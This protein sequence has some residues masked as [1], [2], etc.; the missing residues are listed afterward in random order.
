MHLPPF[1]AAIDAGVAMVMTAHIVVPAWGDAPATLNPVVLGRLR[2]HGLRRRHR[3]R[4][5]RHGGGARDRRRG[6]GRGAG[7]ARRRRPALHRRTRQP[8]CGCRAR[9]GRARLP[10]GAVRRSSTRSTTARCPSACSSGAAAC[11]RSANARRWGITGAGRSADGRRG[12]CGPSTRASSRAAA[13]TVDGAVPAQPGP[14][15]VL[16]VRGRSTLAVDGDA[17]YVETTLAAGGTVVRFPPRADRR[18][19]P[20]RDRRRATTPEPFVGSSTPSAR[21]RPQRDVIEQRPPC[22]PTAIVVNVG[23]PGD[24]LPLATPAHA[25]REPPRRRGRER[26]CSPRARGTRSRM[27]VLSLQS[28]TSADGIDVAVVEIA[29]IDDPAERPAV[30]PARAATPRPWLVGRAPRPHPRRRRRASRSTAGGFCELDTQARPGVRGCRGAAAWRRSGVVPDLIVSHG[31]TVPLGGGRARPR[32]PAARRT[33]VDRRAHGRAR[34]LRRA[35]RRHRRGR[36]GRSAHGGAS[37]ARG[38]APRRDAAGRADRHRQPRRHRE[39][40]ARAAP[41]ATSSRSTAG[42]GNCLI[43]AVV[44]RRLARRRARTTTAAVS[45]RPAVC[46][47]GC[48]SSCCGIRTSRR[49][50]PKSTGRET[51]DLGVVDAAIAA[52]GRVGLGCTTS[53]RRSPSSPPAQSSRRST[54]ESADRTTRPPCSSARAAAP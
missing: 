42:P 37:T 15:T 44:A 20:R 16:D 12:G 34:A 49:P 1:R 23:V 24:A 17:D 50:T 8:R 35:R 32:H 14:R 21:R 36:R 30:A 31:Q 13:L 18:P 29:A 2:A 48:S 5:A 45:R 33:R 51:F 26:R 9:P 52:S 11:A 53:W 41:T 46:T 7:A 54:R 4:R 47:T 19:V 40:A 39:R 10:R 25:G 27:I 22:D 3:H 28:G 6:P 38:S 43:D